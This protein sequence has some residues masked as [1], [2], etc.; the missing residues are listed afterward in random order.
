MGAYIEHIVGWCRAMCSSVSPLW[1]TGGQRVGWMMGGVGPQGV[2][3]ELR[4]PALVPGTVLR[5][6]RATGIMGFTTEPALA[7]PFALPPPCHLGPPWA[8][9]SVCRAF[10]CTSPAAPNTNP[11]H[12]NPA[13]PSLGLLR[14]GTSDVVL[15]V[16][17]HGCQLQVRGSEA[18]ECVVFVRLV[19]T[20]A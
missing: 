16:A 4:G 15:P 18:N 1:R 3:V 8:S 10:A 12:T 2:Y 5:N 14:P 6:R 17:Q 7:P 19:R 13:R 20:Q 11:T 9:A